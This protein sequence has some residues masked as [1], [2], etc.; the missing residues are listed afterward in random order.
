M[1]QS[2]FEPSRQRYSRL[3]RSFLLER[4]P[5]LIPIILLSGG[6]LLGIVSLY[7]GD[8]F[9]VPIPLGLSPTLLYLSSAFVLGISGILASIISIIECLDRCSIRIAA[10][11]KLKEHTYVHRN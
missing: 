10:L 6:T 11:A 4:H 9:P 2:Q 3:R 8:L 1:I 7:T 5:V